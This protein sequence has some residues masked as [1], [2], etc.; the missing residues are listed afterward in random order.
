MSDAQKI[1]TWKHDHDYE[2]DSWE[3]G[4]GNLFVF[5]DGGPV[6]NGFAFCPYCGS[7]LAQE[8]PVCEGEKT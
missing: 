3:S 4:C 5:N 6:D 1:C 7:E 8:I 2:Y